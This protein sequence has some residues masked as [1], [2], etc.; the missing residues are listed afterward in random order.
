M[1]G[2]SQIVKI[3]RT[4]RFFELRW[5]LVWGDQ[6]WKFLKGRDINADLI[7]FVTALNFFVVHYNISLRTIF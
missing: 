3:H 6:L 5:K 4:A 7:Q 2:L 1:I